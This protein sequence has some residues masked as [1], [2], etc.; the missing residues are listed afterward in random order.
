MSEPRPPAEEPTATVKAVMVLWML[1]TLTTLL[2]SLATVAWSWVLA[3]APA[4]DQGRLGSQ[5]LAYLIL[6][7]LGGGLLTLA[8]TMAAQFVPPRRPPILITLAALAIGLA[9]WI[10]YGVLA[11]LE[12]AG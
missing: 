7:A 10:V 4:E 2:L 11:A 5:I 3:A 1:T 8:I 9:P 6:Y 12:W